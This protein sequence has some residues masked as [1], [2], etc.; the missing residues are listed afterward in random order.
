MALVVGVHGIGQQVRGPEV[1]RAVWAP[2]LRD[3]V[4]L[5]G[6]RP[7]DAADI[8]VAFYGDLFREQA[9]KATGEPLYTAIDIADGFEMQLL[10]AWLWA[11]TEF[12][13]TAIK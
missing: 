9:G 10:W 3:G 1:L 12:P 8:A 6:S 5:S 13:R 2:A 7:P 4:F 11:L